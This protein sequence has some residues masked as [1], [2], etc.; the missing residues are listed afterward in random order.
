[1]DTIT[2]AKVGGPPDDW[3]TYQVRDLDDPDGHRLVDGVVEANTEEGWIVVQRRDLFE[4]GM[5]AIPTEKRT[6]RF[7]IER[8]PPA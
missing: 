8:Q 1:M 5:D 6:G 7:V 4:E 2:Y 3:G